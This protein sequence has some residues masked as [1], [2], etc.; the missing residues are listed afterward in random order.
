MAE[1]IGSCTTP[2][3]H[4]RLSPIANQDSAHGEQ[5]YPVGGLKSPIVGDVLPEGVPAVHGL[6]V[7][8]V[9]A[10]LLHHALGLLLER[11][12]GRV[13]P[14]GPEVPVLVILPTCGGRRA[15]TWWDWLLLLC[16]PPGHVMEAWPVT[17]G[18]TRGNGPGH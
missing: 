5:T 15:V 10:V 16:H 14:P 8:A 9:V 12:H 18:T 3:H 11:L 13:L 1:A 4:N 2:S 7:H 17:P 6:P